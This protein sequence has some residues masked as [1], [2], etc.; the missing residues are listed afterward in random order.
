MNGPKFTI[1]PSLHS[2]SG[3]CAASGDKP[4]PSS[5]GTA[6]ASVSRTTDLYAFVGQ[7]S[8]FRHL[9]PTKDVVTVGDFAPRAAMEAPCAASSSRPS[10]ARPGLALL[11]LPSDV[12]T[13][14]VS[15]SAPASSSSPPCASV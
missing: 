11:D 4:L 5:S 8:K 12:L 15:L 14:I 10:S 13:I 6:P 3:R 1:V 9:Q 2:V 7:V